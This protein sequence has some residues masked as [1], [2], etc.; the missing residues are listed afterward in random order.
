MARGASTST[1]P[2]G[3]HFPVVAPGHLGYDLRLEGGPPTR[4]KGDRYLLLHRTD[5]DESSDQLPHL[6]PIVFGD[7]DWERL[8]P[9]EPGG[10]VK[11]LARGSIG[12]LNDGGT[13]SDQIAERSLLK[14]IDIVESLALELCLCGKEGFVLRPKLLFR[15]VKLLKICSWRAQVRYR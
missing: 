15:R 1:S 8:S 10:A 11:Q 5:L 3:A 7:E 12:L 2:N 4:M 6:G 13:V 9:N 14:E